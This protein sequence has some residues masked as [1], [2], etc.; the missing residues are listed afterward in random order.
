MKRLNDL[1]QLCIAHQC[2]LEMYF[3]ASFRSPEWLVIIRY[4]VSYMSSP[5]SSASGEIEQCIESCIAAVNDYFAKGR[6]QKK[7]K[8]K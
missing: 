7:G 2:G 8:I 5:Y 4:P 3:H 6:Q 1:V